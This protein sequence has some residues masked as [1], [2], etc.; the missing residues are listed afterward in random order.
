MIRYYL[1]A[2]NIIYTLYII[3]YNTTIYSYAETITR[4]DG[5]IQLI[6]MER[7]LIIHKELIKRGF[8]GSDSTYSFYFR[9]LCNLCNLRVRLTLVL[10]FFPPCLEKNDVSVRLTLGKIEFANSAQV[11][12]KGV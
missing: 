4:T 6:A 10:R 9:F 11:A 8:S 3:Y 5:R 1:F 2:I 7:R 12:K